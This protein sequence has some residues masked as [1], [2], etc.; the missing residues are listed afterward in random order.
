MKLPLVC[1]IV[2]AVLIFGFRVGLQ[3]RRTGDHGLRLAQQRSTAAELAATGL[4]ACGLLGVLV[5]TGL[6]TLS[7]LPGQ[8]D[9]GSAGAITGVAVCALAVAITMLSQYQMGD[10][11]RIGVDASE[12][13]PL[14]TEGLFKLSRNPIYSGMLLVG[15]GFVILM[16]HILTVCCG[17]VSYVGFEIQVRKVE[18]PYLRSVHGD[19]YL[20]YCR[21]V[22]RYFPRLRDAPNQSSRVSK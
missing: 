22:G 14:V 13:N 8:L 11:W 9:L 20:E 5:L 10:A 12:K 17:L 18:E 19:S 15:V 4:Q 1:F 3:L 21:N 2:C 7:Y 16:P 6:D